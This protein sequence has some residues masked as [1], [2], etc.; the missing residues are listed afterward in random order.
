[1][2]SPD[3]QELLPP[4]RPAAKPVPWRALLAL[5]VPAAALAGGTGLHR[6]FESGSG[7][8]LLHWLA[9]SSG[10]GLAVGALAGLLRRQMFWPAYGLVSPWLLAGLL[11]GLFRV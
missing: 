4:P 10:A 3:T 2:S 6:L 7:D 5:F 11:W 8:P 1:V 9:W